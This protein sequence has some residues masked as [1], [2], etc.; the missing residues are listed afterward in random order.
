MTKMN[1]E[2]SNARKVEKRRAEKAESALAAIE[3]KVDVMEGKI[4]FF[5][6][7]WNKAYRKFEIQHAWQV[8][9]NARLDEID[10]YLAPDDNIQLKGKL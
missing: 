9:M 2:E 7:E 1:A 8:I 6:D 4:D 5:S 3:H 10:K